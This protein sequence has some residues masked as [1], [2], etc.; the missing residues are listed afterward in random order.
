MLVNLSNH[1]SCKWNKEQLY[2][3]KAKYGTILDMPFPYIEPTADTPTVS[4]LAGVYFL[5]ILACQPQAVHLMGEMTF[6]FELVNRLRK[7][8][9]ICLASTTERIVEEKKDERV[10]KFQF[11]RFRAY[12]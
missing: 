10:V 6:T 1:P 3:A 4:Q 11:I 9:I 2:E 5:E 8:Q 7:A 12:A